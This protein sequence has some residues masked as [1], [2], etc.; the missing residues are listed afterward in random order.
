[1][2]Y[3][4]HMQLSNELESVARINLSFGLPWDVGGLIKYR[5]LCQ[6]LSPSQISNT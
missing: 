5:S 1:M 2:T 4:E 3:E 6:V